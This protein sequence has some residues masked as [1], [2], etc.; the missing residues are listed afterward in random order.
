MDGQIGPQHEDTVPGTR[1]C[2]LA[3]SGSLDPVLET[4][5]AASA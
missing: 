4:V 2:G 1:G 5:E 3:G